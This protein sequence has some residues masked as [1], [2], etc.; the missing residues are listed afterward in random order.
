MPLKN[1]YLTLLYWTCKILH[2]LLIFFYLLFCSMRGKYAYA[3]KLTLEISYIYFKEVNWNILLRYMIR[4]LSRK[5]NRI[6]SLS[7]GIRAFI[8]YLK[9]SAFFTNFLITTSIVMGRKLSIYSHLIISFLA[10]FIFQI[11]NVLTE[12]LNYRV[13]LSEALLQIW[14]R[15]P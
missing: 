3:C 13:R 9:I 6:C 2:H 1:I 15:N 4:T 7:G 10:A 5:H 14:L 8:Q 11:K 12:P